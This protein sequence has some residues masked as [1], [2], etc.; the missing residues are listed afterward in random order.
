MR[1]KGRG[2][3][4]S[5]TPATRGGYAKMIKAAAVNLTWKNAL[6]PPKM[7]SPVFRWRASA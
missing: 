6:I 1:K 5:N 4:F 3:A 7:V 2:V